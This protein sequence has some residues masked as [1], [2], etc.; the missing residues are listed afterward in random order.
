MKFEMCLFLDEA[1]YW[2]KKLF[3]YINLLPLT[4]DED[5]REVKHDVYGRR[6][7]AKIT[8]DFLFFSCNP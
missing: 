1:S 7:T 4:P 2:A 8:Y 6:Q 3:T 5:I